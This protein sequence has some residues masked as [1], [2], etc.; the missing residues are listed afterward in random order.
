MPSLTLTPAPTAALVGAGIALCLL[1][2]YQYRQVSGWT[3][4][5]I[6]PVLGWRIIAP[7]QVLAGLLAAFLLAPGW[8]APAAVASAGF[9]WLSVLAI[10]T[11]LVTHKVPWD[12]SYPPAALGAACFAY[13]YTLEG[14]LALGTAALGVVGIPFLARAGTRKGLGMSDIRLLVAA[15]ATTAWWVGQT[16]LLY[17]LIAASVAQLGVRILAPRFG[18][19]AHVA[20]P[21]DEEGRTRLE[22]PFAPALLL[23]IWAFLV[24][25]TVTG[26]GA[27]QMWNPFGCA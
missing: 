2:V 25:A 7:A 27:C 11:D 23:A 19:G 20:I 14:A 22:L 24:Y 5:G 9:A 16:W 6:Y 18:W 8:G 3:A 12:I 10:A 1:S 17:A 21:D 13:A 4:R 26:Y 15:T